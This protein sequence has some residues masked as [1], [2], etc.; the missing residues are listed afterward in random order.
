MD[1]DIEN[2]LRLRTI[3]ISLLRQ[4]KELEIAMEKA[5][6]NNP[7][8][9]NK[10]NSD[11]MIG[12]YDYA[13]SASFKEKVIFALKKLRSASFLDI[14]RYLEILGEDFSQHKE[15]EAEIV[16]LLNDLVSENIITKKIQNDN[17]THLYNYLWKDD[18]R[19][20]F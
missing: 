17:S 8:T 3:R 12:R 20:K 1:I 7:V 16:E 6:P 11:I 9:L 14:K 13:Q 2:Y 10:L 5:K 4:V 18:G 19:L 15:V